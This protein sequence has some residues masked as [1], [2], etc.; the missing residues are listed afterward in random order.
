MQVPRSLNQLAQVSNKIAHDK[1]WWEKPRSRSVITL[2]MQSEVS[3]VIEE[4]R[5]H[6][7]PTEVWYEKS[8]SEGGVK[9]TTKGGKGDKPCGIPIELA[10]FVIR[11]ADYAEE[12]R[13]DLERTTVKLPIISNPDEIEEYLAR[14]NWAISM[15]WMA[16]NETALTEEF[17]LAL[18]IKYAFDLAHGFEIDLWAAIDEKTEYNLTRPHRHG[19]KRI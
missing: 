4:H 10:D 6:H 15:A 19:N 13:Y 17:F 8:Y 5:E 16:S 14:M 18:A 12:Q 3:E 9:Y 2:L 1:G 11:I 7:E